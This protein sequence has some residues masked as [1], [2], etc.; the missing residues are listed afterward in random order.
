MSLKQVRNS[1]I[2][3]AVAKLNERLMRPLTEPSMGCNVRLW[4][5]KLLCTSQP[6]CK[7]D[8]VAPLWILI[9]RSAAKFAPCLSVITNL[10]GDSADDSAMV[11]HSP[12]LKA[13]SVHS[14]DVVRIDCRWF[15]DLPTTDTR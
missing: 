14:A 4:Q 10:T 2:E 8:Q 11:A 7:Q 1:A 15:V 3:P 9:D 5:P 13:C 12:S 6:M